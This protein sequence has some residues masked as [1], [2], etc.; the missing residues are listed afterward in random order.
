MR[1]L[2]VT[3]S[4]LQQSLC[5]QPHQEC[6][7]ANSPACFSNKRA[8]SLKE[9]HGWLHLFKDVLSPV[10]FWMW[11]FSWHLRTV[12]IAATRVWAFSTL[13][14]LSWMVHVLL[15][16]TWP[17]RSCIKDSLCLCRD[18]VFVSAPGAALCPVASEVIWGSQWGLPQEEFLTPQALHSGLGPLQNGVCYVPDVKKGW[19]RNIYVRQLLLGVVQ[20]K[21][22][23]EKWYF[24]SQKSLLVALRKNIN[25]YK[26]EKI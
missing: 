13:R 10:R 16:G 20:I 11:S 26:N 2:W 25:S 22:D 5:R 19:Y 18:P 14:K 7:V 17:S 24:H 8:I 15:V 1:A 3:I 23:T 6:A 21:E 12:M 4:R 9:Q